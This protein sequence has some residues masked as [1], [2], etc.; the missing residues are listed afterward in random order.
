MVRVCVCVRVLLDNPV[1]RMKGHSYMQGSGFIQIPFKPRVCV[2][3]CVCVRSLFSS[4]CVCVCVCVC[5]CIL[6]GRWSEKAEGEG[7][8]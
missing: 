6:Q 5:V 2:C 1:S 4:L 7:G 3:V 8:F